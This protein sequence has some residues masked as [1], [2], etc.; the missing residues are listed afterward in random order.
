ME[1][2]Q[3][4]VEPRTETGTWG[5]K[6]LR[7]QG[8][9]P[10]V[11]YG[12]GI[13][14]AVLQVDARTLAESLRHGHVGVLVDLAFR[15]DGGERTETVMLREVQRNPITGQ[16]LNVDFHRISLTEEITTAVP[17]LLVGEPESAKRGGILEQILWEVNVSCLPTN[18][19]DHFEVDVSRIEIGDTLHASALAVPEGVTL[20]VEP[21]E[22]LVVMAA[23]RV[24]EE[25]AAPTAEELAEEE[26]AEPELVGKGKKEEEAEGAQ[27]E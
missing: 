15:E 12:K 10:A 8:L 16:L 19:P 2:V 22:V 11:M 3:I 13:E 24:E 25:A 17:I 1:R 18:I 5:A 6:R 20:Q 26:A 4:P 21:E 27:E 23:A 14:P 9:V 7:K